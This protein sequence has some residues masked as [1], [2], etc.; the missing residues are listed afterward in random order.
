MEW[1]FRV[2]GEAA[3][4][5]KLET[6]RVEA[7]SAK[8]WA[9]G[10]DSWRWDNKPPPHHLGCLG[11]GERCMQGDHLSGKAAHVNDFVKGK[12]V[13]KSVQKLFITGC[14]F[15]FIWVFSGIQCIATYI[16][17][18]FIFCNHYEVIVNFWSFTLTSSTGMLWVPLSMGMSAAHCQRNAGEMSGNFRVYGEWSPC[19]SSSSGVRS[20]LSVQSPGRQEFWCILGFSGI[21]QQL[22]LVPA[23]WLGLR[24]GAFT[25]IGWQ[26]KLW[27]HGKWRPV[28][29]RWSTH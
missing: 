8:S 27:F 20:C 9:K 19:V 18:D 1:T 5:P 2:L 7:R 25:C 26:V 10:W 14:I 12:V 3:L 23:Y 4:G 16:H 29:V 17:S 6:R 22:N 15:A 24:R 13:W 28:P 21:S 11:I